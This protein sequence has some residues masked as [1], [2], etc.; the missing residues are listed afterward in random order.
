MKCNK[1]EMEIEGGAGHS[2]ERLVEMS[3]A[4]F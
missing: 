2:L 1:S 4:K 3:S